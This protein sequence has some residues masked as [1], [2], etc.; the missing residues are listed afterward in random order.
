[1][2]AVA[3]TTWRNT[4]KCERDADERKLPNGQDETTGFVEE[5]FVPT[6]D[7]GTSVPDLGFANPN[8]NAAVLPQLSPRI[9]G[10]ATI[11]SGNA[12][13]FTSSWKKESLVWTEA[14]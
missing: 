1:M 8:P 3:P 10:T 14:H 12:T 9:L 7:M 5:G 13:A 6:G 11:R 2:C 4:T